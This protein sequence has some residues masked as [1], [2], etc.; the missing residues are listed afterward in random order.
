MII[1]ILLWLNHIF[2]WHA[3]L[4]LILLTLVLELF[5]WNLI[6]N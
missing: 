5:V 2:Q 4:W 1:V 6:V 3:P